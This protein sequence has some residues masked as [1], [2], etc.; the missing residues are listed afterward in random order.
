MLSFFRLASIAEQYKYA[1]RHILSSWPRP[2]GNSVHSV[3]SVQQVLRYYY[4]RGVVHMGCRNWALAVRSFWTCLSIPGPDQNVVSAVAIA[5]WKKLVL[6]QCCQADLLET[7]VPL[8]HLSQS[9]VK[10]VLFG[11]ATQK[12]QPQKGPLA[13]PKEM[14]AGMTRYL[15]TAAPPPGSRSVGIATTNRRLP[16][17]LPDA[18]FLEVQHL[19]LP[20]IIPMPCTWW[21]SKAKQQL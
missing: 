1:E 16:W 8:E 5:A 7:C 13:T 21:K 11:T 19:Q 6:V 3:K 20:R 10:S 18:A 9:S 14:S 17:R 12:M 4:L 15:S 2:N